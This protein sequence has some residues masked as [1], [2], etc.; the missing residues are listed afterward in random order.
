MGDE[1]VIDGLAYRPSTDTLRTF[2]EYPLR[3][4][5]FPVIVWTGHE[6]IVWGG[7]KTALGNRIVDP[8]PPLNNGAAYTPPR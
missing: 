5:E 4:R 3:E 6:L 2:P 8:P 7:A 1:I